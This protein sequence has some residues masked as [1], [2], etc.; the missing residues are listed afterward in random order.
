MRQIVV[1]Q[2]FNFNFVVDDLLS[3]HVINTNGKSLE[4]VSGAKIFKTI[5]TREI[6]SWIIL[7]SSERRLHI[8]NSTTRWTFSA[9]LIFKAK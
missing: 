8:V 3:P 2:N 5:G 1:G 4:D 7:R 6:L 9:V